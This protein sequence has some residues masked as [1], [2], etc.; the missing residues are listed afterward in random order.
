MKIGARILLIFKSQFSHVTLYAPS[1]IHRRAIR[2]GLLLMNKRLLSKMLHQ[3]VSGLRSSLGYFFR[4]DFEYVLRGVAF[5]YVPRGLYI[6][7]FRF[8]LFD[9]FGPNLT[10]SDR[11]LERGGFIGN[12]EMSEEAIVDFVMSSP[13]VRNAFVQDKP[14]ELPD[15]VHYIELKPPRSLENPGVR[16]V[17]AAALI[18]LGQE[19]RAANLL[20]ELAP[21]LDRE[22]DIANYNL[23]R[24]SLR[25]GFE[26]ARA[27]LE[28]VRQKNL[29]MLGVIL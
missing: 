26:T 24:T 27:V 5:D 29:Q 23:L 2:R 28:Q 3:R 19:L 9:P 8:P 11:L 18:L 13:E 10:Y 7:D 20:D 21:S 12:G 6:E 14:A 4:G 17:Y 25:Q 22:K 1:R 16:F 15:F